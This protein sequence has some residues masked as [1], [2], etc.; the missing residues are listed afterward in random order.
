[1]NLRILTPFLVLLALAFTGFAISK[2]Q[3]P[4]SA[5]EKRELEIQLEQLEGEIDGYEKTISEYKKQ[6]ASLKGEIGILDA[7][8]SKLN[9]QIKAVNLSIARL[10]SEITVTSGKINSTQADIDEN[11]D[12]L[13]ETIKNIY[14]SDKEGMLKV[15]LKSSELSDFLTNVNSLGILQDKL[16]IQLQ[17]LVD[18]RNELLSQKEQLSLARNDK[19]AQKAYQ[20]SQKSTIT[21]TKSQKNNLLKITKGKESEFQKYL[22]ETQKKAAQVRSRIFEFLGGGAL[23]FDQAYQFA[24]VASIATGVRPALLLAVLD[25]ESALGKNVGQCD[26]KTAMHP[27]RDIP[28]FLTIIAELGLQSDLDRGIIK[29]SCANSDGAYGGAMGPSQFIPS[30]WSLYNARIASITGSNPPSPWKSYDAITAT[31]LYL[32]DAGAA[33]ASIAKEREAAA[34]YYAGGRWK[35]YLWTYGARVVSKA[36]EFQQDIDLLNSQ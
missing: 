34:R 31:A 25:K 3:T 29:V 33:N 4:P 10:D 27:T 15:L 30:T 21:S 13:T 1:M 16:R 26:Y 28:V 7:K 6:G 17:K 14:F 23:T 11:K 32:K 22:A 18:D 9:L 20:D 36:E 12:V 5:E 19:A 24:K 2:A 35:N 8:I